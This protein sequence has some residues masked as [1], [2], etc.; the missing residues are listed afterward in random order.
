MSAATIPRWWEG[1]LCMPMVHSGRPGAPVTTLASTINVAVR[2]GAS[3]L[4][5]G[6]RARR[7]RPGAPF[8]YVRGHYA[9]CLSPRQTARYRM[10]AQIRKSENA[11]LVATGNYWVLTRAPNV[12]IR[13][14]E[15]RNTA[16]RIWTAIRRPWPLT[17]TGGRRRRECIDRLSPPFIRGGRRTR[18]TTCLL[19]LLARGVPH[20]S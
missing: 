13:C 10:T 1:E 9:R 17:A 11:D 3:R 2:F 19:P 16:C 15:G 5:R 14:V 6:R 4:S 12:D 7:A 20:P 8:L 18:G